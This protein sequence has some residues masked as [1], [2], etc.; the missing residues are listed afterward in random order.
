[1]ATKLTSSRPA[2]LRFSS[3]GR[4]SRAA[5]RANQKNER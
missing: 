2:W 3:A 1:M 4:S 5:I